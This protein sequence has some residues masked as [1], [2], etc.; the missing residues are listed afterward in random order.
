M[1]KEF[2]EYKE[3]LK[4]LLFTVNRC[5]SSAEEARDSL[6]SL[7][8]VKVQNPTQLK[9]QKELQKQARELEVAMGL[10]EFGDCPICDDHIISEGEIKKCFYCDWNNTWSPEKTCETYNKYWDNAKKG[11]RRPHKEAKDFIKEALCVCGDEENQHIDNC[12]QCVIAE[13]GCK[14]FEEPEVKVQNPDQPADDDEL[15]VGFGEER[16]KEE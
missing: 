3:A 12:E 10:R 13:C 11:F 14:Q 8:E 9:E 16:V 7:L 2:N 4:E 5:I 1:N 6:E 15:T